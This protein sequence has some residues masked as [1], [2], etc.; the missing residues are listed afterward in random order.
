MPQTFL[1][2]RIREL[3]LQSIFLD[4]HNIF[5]IA[6]TKMVDPMALQNTPARVLQG[7]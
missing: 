7:N 1:I 2:S 5:L 4:A 3:Q 6:Y